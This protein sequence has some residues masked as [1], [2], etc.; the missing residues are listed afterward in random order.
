MLE[1]WGRVVHRYRWLVLAASTVLLGASGVLVAGGGSLQ[2]PS[3]LSSSESGRASQL[4]N[5]QL[6]RATGTPAGTTFLLVFEGAPLAVTDPAF[7]AAV[8][9]AIAPLRS[10]PRV[11]SMRTYYDAPAQSASLVSHEYPLTKMHI[12]GVAERNRM[13]G[14]RWCPHLQ[15]GHVG[16]GI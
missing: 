7:Q 8:N 12:V 3:S 14:T 4:I 11:Q 15:N 2:D 1:R 5:D 9:D 6:P 13:Q 10:D 16:C